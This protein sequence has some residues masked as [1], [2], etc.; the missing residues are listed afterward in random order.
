MVGTG[1]QDINRGFFKMAR[2]RTCLITVGMTPIEK[3]K[4][5]EDAEREASEESQGIRYG[6]QQQRL[7][8]DR[9]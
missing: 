3:E 8:S 5:T 2:V 1:G 9:R 7:S 4:K 6:V